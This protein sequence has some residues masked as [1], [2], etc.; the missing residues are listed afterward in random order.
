MDGEDTVANLPFFPPS[1]L[2]HFTESIAQ[3]S[4]DII[5]LNTTSPSKIDLSSILSDVKNADG[6]NINMEGD[7]FSINLS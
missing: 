2:L 6:G 7:V 4:P 1:F 3:E 5:S